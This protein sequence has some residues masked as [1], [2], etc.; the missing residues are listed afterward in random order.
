MS[1]KHTYPKFVGF[2]CDED[3]YNKLYEMKAS[4]PAGI[5]DAFWFK[6]IID[7]EYRKFTNDKSHIKE[8][9]DFCDIIETLVLPFM[10]ACNY[11]RADVKLMEKRLSAIREYLTSLE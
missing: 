8:L 4:M 2:R 5:T 1:K 3:T 9:N 10:K 11:R 7:A 6:S